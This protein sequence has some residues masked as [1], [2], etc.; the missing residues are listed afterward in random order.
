VVALSPAS[1]RCPVEVSIGGLNQRS[2]RRLGVSCGR[3]EGVKRCL[4]TRRCDFENRASAVSSAAG[5]CP[6]EISIGGLNQTGV[7][8]DAVSC[9]GAECI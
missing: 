3:A 4:R 2:V 6:V 7:R 8:A 1:L 9:C 5:G